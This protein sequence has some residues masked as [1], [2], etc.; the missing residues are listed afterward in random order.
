MNDADSDKEGDANKGDGLGDIAGG[1][2]QTVGA[3]SGWGTVGKTEMIVGEDETPHAT[4]PQGEA[5]QAV[6]PPAGTPEAIA[7]N[8]A[9]PTLAK[10]KKEAVAEQ[11]MYSLLNGLLSRLPRP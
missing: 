11:T 3:A 1:L 10:S 5:P 6:I 8:S 4:T 2:D 7:P 9:L